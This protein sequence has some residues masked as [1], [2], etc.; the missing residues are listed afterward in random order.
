MWIW[1]KSQRYP[2]VS[3]LTLLD[4]DSPNKFGA[5]LLQGSRPHFLGSLG[6]EARLLGVSIR[7]DTE[8]VGYWDSADEQAVITRSGEVIRGDVTWRA[9]TD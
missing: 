2:E 1:D 3:L 4:F 7:L 8:V 6:V 5:P 9:C